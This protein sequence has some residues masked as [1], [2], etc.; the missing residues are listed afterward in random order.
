MSDECC[1]FCLA[2]SGPLLERS[3]PY[4]GHEGRLLEST[5]WTPYQQAVELQD[6]WV[7]VWEHLASD[8]MLVCP[9]HANGQA[10]PRAP[11]TALVGDVGINLQEFDYVGDRED[12]AMLKH[13]RTRRARVRRRREIAAPGGVGT[14]DSGRRTLHDGCPP[15][16][17]SRRN[18]RL[19]ERTRS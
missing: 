6:G 15:R 12:I 8:A 14:C 18:R 4:D 2:G 11:A 5:A 17:P 1:E 10:V 13:V 19:R 3:R 16:A 9:F 7:A